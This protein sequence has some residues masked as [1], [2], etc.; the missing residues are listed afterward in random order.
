MPVYNPSPTGHTDPRP[1]G[2]E[3]LGRT[4]A[5][6]ETDVTNK[7]KAQGLY[8]IMVKGD[9]TRAERLAAWEEMRDLVKS[10]KTSFA[11]LTGSHLDFKLL[12]QEIEALPD[13]KE[14]K[15]ADAK[16]NAGDDFTLSEEELAKQKGR[17]EKDPLEETVEEK[18]KEA[19]MPEQGEKAVVATER[20]LI[21]AMV[22]EMLLKTDEPYGE[23]EKAVRAKFPHAKT[24]TR[25]IASV[26]S[27]MRKAKQAVAQRRVP[28]VPK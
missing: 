8:D 16:L 11:K 25:S 22:R 7:E 21:S 3:P 12:G 27:D 9:Y 28:A 14:E 1:I 13:A 19:V 26:A 4:G 20:G 2:G 23:I 18:V 24:T 10:S 15:A 17:P 6:E 5:A